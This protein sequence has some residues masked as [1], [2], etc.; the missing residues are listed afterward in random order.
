MNT[1]SNT[2]FIRSGGAT[3]PNVFLA[4]IAVAGLLCA[5]CNSPGPAMQTQSL[6]PE[7]LEHR[8]GETPGTL[9]YGDVVR[10]TF[11]GAPDLNT[12]Q[13][14]RADGKISLPLV[15][16][17]QADGIPLGVFQEE[18]TRL[19]KPELQ[20]S[21][22]L[23]TV[24]STSTPVYVTGAVLT[25]GRVLLERPM[26]A[27]EAIM[28]A[29]GFVPGRSNPKRVILVRQENG[30]HQTQVLNLSSLLRGQPTSAVPLRPYDVIYV[31]EKWF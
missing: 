21:E 16:E 24:D 15:G 8:M 23:V 25:P 9:A 4:I 11:P 26:S 13:K 14:I 17:V 2:P 19:Y 28:E 18:L 22:V 3:H 7:A 29:G 12:L 5:G 1:H 31:P 30:R 10:V 20:R 6:P 27:V